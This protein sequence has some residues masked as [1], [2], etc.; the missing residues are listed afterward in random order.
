MF[1]SKYYRKDSNLSI[2]LRRRNLESESRVLEVS[3]LMVVG[4]FKYYAKVHVPENET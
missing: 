1:E 2:I 3:I 4:D